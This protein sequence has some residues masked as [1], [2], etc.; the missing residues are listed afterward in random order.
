MFECPFSCSNISVFR[1]SQN[2]L[3]S[4]TKLIESMWIRAEPEVDPQNLNLD[5]IFSFLQEERNIETKMGHGNKTLD[6][7]TDELNELNELLTE[8]MVSCMRLF[9]IFRFTTK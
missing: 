5:E 2:E 4:L 6:E 9:L 3:D 7:I 8:D 1:E